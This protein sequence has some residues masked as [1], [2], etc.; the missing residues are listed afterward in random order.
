MASSW[1]KNK[2]VTNFPRNLINT[3]DRLLSGPWFKIWNSNTK[4]SAGVVRRQLDSIRHGKIKKN[5]SYK[6]FKTHKLTYPRA[7]V[8]L[9][10]LSSHIQDL[11]VIAYVDVDD[12]ILHPHLS[13]NY[14]LETENNTS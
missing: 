3:F 5:Y 13:K 6:I 1:I 12:A 10:H 7:V 9:R 2:N 14:T 4:K 11:S 8:L